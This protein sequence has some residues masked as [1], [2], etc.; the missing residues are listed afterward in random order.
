[1]LTPVDISARLRLDASVLLPLATGAQPPAPMPHSPR[2]GFGGAAP[3]PFICGHVSCSPVVFAFDEWQSASL[4]AAVGHASAV[5]AATARVV[6]AAATTQHVP[7]LASNREYIEVTRTLLL[8]DDLHDERRSQ[9][10]QRGDVESSDRNCGSSA[11][12]SA[13]AESGA[14]GGAK[15]SDAAKGSDGGRTMPSASVTDERD[16]SGG[17]GW[18]GGFSQLLNLQVSRKHFAPPHSPRVLT[19]AM[20]RHLC[21]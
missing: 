16:A 14:L 2:A 17:E 13:T 20:A 15:G 11:T 3:S 18:G 19:Q 5:W 9:R 12:M 6:Q 4:V 8:A 7:S 1:M 21:E 10:D